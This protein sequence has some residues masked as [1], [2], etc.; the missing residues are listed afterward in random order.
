MREL[1]QN[2][3]DI[4]RAF[5]IAIDPKKMMLGFVGALISLGVVILL[6][7]IF[8]SVFPNGITRVADVILNPSSETC[9]ALGQ[10]IMARLTHPGWRDIGFLIITG[11]LLCAIWSFIGG[12][13]IRSSAVE[14]ARDERI[15][16]EESTNFA[17]KKFSSFFWAPVVPCL[18]I[19]FFLL[20]IYI[21]GIVGRIPYL[22]PLLVGIFFFLAVLAGIVIVLIGIGTAVGG[23]LMWPTI[24]VEGTDAF[25]A[26]SRSFS[27]IYGRPWKLI[28]YSL[29]GLGYGLVCLAF[30]A[31]F[32]GLTLNVSMG[33]GAA[34]MGA[35]FE[36]IGEVITGSVHDAV[37]PPATA[38]DAPSVVRPNFAQWFAGV[39]MKAVIVLVW[40]MVVG[41]AISMCMTLDTIIY[42][43]LR[44][45]V[46]GTDMTEVF[47]EEE[48][49][50]EEP[51]PPASEEPKAESAA[52]SEEAGAVEEPSAG[53]EK[54]DMVED[55]S[56]GEE[57]GGQ[58]DEEGGDKKDDEE[59]KDQD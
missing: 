5:R 18:A 23:M 12:S 49:E 29:V 38:G 56:V 41:F 48:E 27:Y 52:P 14:F 8:S 37:I 19:A 35:S 15:A 33:A 21:G 54:A 55:S 59:E 20:C 50:E 44:K 46:D 47:I 43:L 9:S 36:P 22:G 32:A 11:L 10:S 39:L 13:I 57:E 40:G 16:L 58:S 4:F 53:E 42:S 30:V 28:W 34:G 45:N 25:D 1:K 7:L 51:A 6:L 2:W 26:I 17:K 3:L 31:V 24:C